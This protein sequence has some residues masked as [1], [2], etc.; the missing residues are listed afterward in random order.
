VLCNRQQHQ[1]SSANSVA[2]WHS[3]AHCT[4]DRFSQFHNC[5]QMAAMMALRKGADGS[6]V[7]SGVHHRGWVVTRCTARGRN[8]QNIQ[9]KRDGQPS[10]KVATLLEVCF[11][12]V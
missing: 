7:Q 11:V 6:I 5:H 12:S 10:N 8:F 4:G 3:A 2:R 9:H 1:D